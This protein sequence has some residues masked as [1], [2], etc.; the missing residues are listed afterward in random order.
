MSLET[1]PERDRRTPMVRP[2]ASA[3]LLCSAA[4]SVHLTKKGNIK[5][6]PDLL[7]HESGQPIVDSDAGLLGQSQ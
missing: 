3:H 4:A 6:L 1:V 5:A 7:S 2:E